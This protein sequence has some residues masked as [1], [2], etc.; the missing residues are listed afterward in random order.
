MQPAQFRQRPDMTAGKSPSAHREFEVLI[1]NAVVLAE[2]GRVVKS[3]IHYIVAKIRKMATFNFEKLT[4]NAPGQIAITSQTAGKVNLKSKILEVRSTVKVLLTYNEKYYVGFVQVCTAN[5][6]VNH[7][8]PNV[9]QKWEFSH[10]IVSDAGASNERPWYGTRNEGFIGGL[11]RIQLDGPSIM[12]S[13]QFNMSDFF[14]PGI[15][16]FE[17]LANHNAGP[18]QLTRITRDQSFR[19]WLVAVAVSQQAQ[20]NHYIKFAK[21][22][23]RYEYDLTV[24]YAGPTASIVVNNGALTYT[25]P[26]HGSLIPALPLAA[27]NTPT[28]NDNQQLSRYVNGGLANV[29]VP[30]NA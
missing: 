16:K 2:L 3:N 26:T 12:A 8:G 7:Y 22:D 23:W 24:N 20:G 1:G 30:R 17:T 5:S 15:A 10:P 21:V 28:A 13:K 4:V 18:N 29:I 19:L 11:R 27:F 25:A 14:V 9:E 6:Q